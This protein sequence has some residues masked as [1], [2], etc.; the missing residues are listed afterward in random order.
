MGLNK[1]V[2][3]QSHADLP[4]CNHFLHRIGATS[5]QSL[6][7]I[8]A[9]ACTLEPSALLAVAAHPLL[10]EVQDDPLLPLAP[11]ATSAAR[12]RAVAL[13]RRQ[14]LPWGI[15]RIGA[16]LAWRYSKGQG[17]SVAVVDTG[18]DL[19]HP[20]LTPNLRGGVNLVRPGQPPRD[21][22]GHGTHVAGILAAANTGIGVIG[23]APRAELY[24]V[25]A[26]DRAG[27]AQASRI[28]AAIGWCLEHGMRVI[29]LSFGSDEDSMA[30]RETVTK[31]IRSGVIL[32]AAAGN[33]RAAG[34]DVPARYDDVLA[35]TAITRVD[36]A[37]SYAARGPEIDLAAPGQD[38]LSTARGGGYRRQSG[39]S[40]AAPH[41]AG[42][43]A[44]TIARH[45]D[46]SADEVVAHLAATAER[47]DG[48]QRMAQGAGL[49]RADWALIP[50]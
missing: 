36:K 44:L 9:T 28:I 32:V 34:V 35:V 21:D 38:V 31:A 20:N 4:A 10:R 12:Q 30:L 26:F 2:L 22:N 41:V 47:L 42:T 1:I 46:W 24:V 37:L 43:A 49:I 23:V 11:C 40:M 16:H 39:T 14:V 29:N 5:V 6:P 8:H 17:V 13:G 19:E 25:K 50:S 48:V 27:A 18:V 15:R 3:W 45:P 33:K 7:I